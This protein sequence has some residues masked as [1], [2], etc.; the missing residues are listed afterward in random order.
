[1]FPF[2]RGLPVDEWEYPPIGIYFG[3]CPSGG[4]D[5]I[6]LDYRKCGPKG[7]PTVVHVDQEDD[8]EVRP[9]SNT[10]VDFIRELQKPTEE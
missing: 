7:E 10:F 8:F 9:I 1:M 5:M 3:N 6:A 2:L 4:H